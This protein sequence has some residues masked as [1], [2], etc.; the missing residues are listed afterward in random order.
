[1]LIKKICILGGTGFVGRV[2]ANRLVDRGYSL[3]ILTRNREANKENIILLPATDLVEAN[4]HDP[5][6]L[7]QQLAGCDAV[8]NLVG[9]LNERSRNGTGFHTMHVTLTEKI[10]EACR[11][12][13]IRRLLHMSALNADAAKGPSH[14]LKSKG[15]GEN[16]VHAAD[17]IRATSFRPSVI[18][19][20]NDSFFNRFAGLLKLSPGIFPLACPGARF[21]PV[22]VGDVA[23]AMCESLSDPDYYG[24]R[25][26]LCGPGTYTLEELVRYTAK[27]IDKKRL[28][29]PLPDFISRLQG[30]FFDMSGFVFNMLGIEKPFSTD[31]YLST[32][33]DS[34]CSP[35]SFA[36]MGINPVALE[37][38]VPQYL[39][40]LSYRTHYYEFRRHSHR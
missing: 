15:E 33:V 35:S 11:A 20:E 38:V 26:D 2:L 25:L 40:G 12:N 31:N 10:I 17:G 16:L 32:K 22:Y 28:I 1:M 30:T 4:I 8:I 6:E 29:I 21:A 27:C 13:G 3:R 5:A 23:D 34:V 24:K 18:F 37:S 19:G 14:Y 39:A 7:K 9:I 36:E